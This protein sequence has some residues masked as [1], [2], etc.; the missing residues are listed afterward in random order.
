M[1]RKIHFSFA[2]KGNII[3]DDK[4][5]VT[6]FRKDVA[7]LSQQLQHILLSIHQYRINV[8]YQ[9]VPDL[10]IAEWL[11]RQNHMEYKDGEIASMNINIGY[12]NITSD[13]TTKGIKIHMKDDAQLQ[14][15]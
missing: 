7:I 12:I 5:L 10:H 6:G 2:R 14:D 3:T 13:I 1:P 11:S 4:P 8:I 15:L 9:L